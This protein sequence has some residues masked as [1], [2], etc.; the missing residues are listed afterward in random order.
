MGRQALLWLVGVVV[1]LQV[2]STTPAL[3]R[4]EALSRSGAVGSRN[5]QQM[6]LDA[7]RTM[8]G[9]SASGDAKKLADVQ[10]NK[11]VLVNGT[12]NAN[13]MVT[14]NLTVVGD[15]NVEAV[16]TASRVRA[17]MVSADIVEAGILRSPTG[18]I[19]IDGNLALDGGLRGDSAAPVF[20][21]TSE[22]LVDGVAQW[23]LWQHDH[24]EDG[25]EGWSMQTRGTCNA[26]AAAA[27]ETAP[28]ADVFLGGWQPC[29]AAA[30]AAANATKTFKDMPPHTHV[31]L[32]AAMHFFDRWN[33]ESAFASV[34]GLYVWADTAKLTDAQVKSGLN[35]CGAPYP[36]TRLAAPIDVTLKHSASTLTVDFSSTLHGNA[37][38]H[39]WAVDD[40][41][42]YV[43]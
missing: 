16:L 35:I 40:V 12:L 8:L 2:P 14:K 13:T 29:D 10:I 7:G 39:S 33:G 32:K 9:V 6:V 11:R 41:A 19:T 25:A 15:A 23:R 1:A 22:M 3:A 30:D 24:F 38:E 4:H 42:V 31:R 20:L 27:T 34:D 43:R 18:T 37:C 36:E 5:A 17:T 28:P 26:A 21:Q